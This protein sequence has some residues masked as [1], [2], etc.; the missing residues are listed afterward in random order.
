[1][2]AVFY[3]SSTRMILAA[4][5]S[6][7]FTIFLGPPFIKKL[8]ELKMGQSIRTEDCP[9]LAQM[10]EKKK[11]TP[12]MGGILILVA[13]MVSL[14]LWMNLKS[15]F[16]LILLITTIWLGWIGGYDDY[17]KLKYKNS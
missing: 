13:I 5:T 7:L 16:T 8:Y 15:S 1:M 2:P 4:L 3:Y 17:L 9:V 14:F 12:T 6:L 11:D 10:H